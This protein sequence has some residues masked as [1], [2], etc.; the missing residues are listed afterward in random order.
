MCLAVSLALTQR[1]LGTLLEFVPRNFSG[2]GNNIAFPEWGSVGITQVLALQWCTRAVSYLR[3][4]NSLG[5]CRQ[6]CWLT[7]WLDFF[8]VDSLSTVAG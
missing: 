7:R 3:A 8:L 5:C 4:V 1:A 6:L 2:A